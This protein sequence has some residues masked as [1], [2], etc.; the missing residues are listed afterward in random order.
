VE[1]AKNSSIKRSKGRP[2]EKEVAAPRRS[3]VMGGLLVRTRGKPNA[4]VKLGYK[5][6]K[7]RAGDGEGLG[8]VF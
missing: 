4:G 2:G 6:N 3:L 5:I 7:N 8:V 1:E